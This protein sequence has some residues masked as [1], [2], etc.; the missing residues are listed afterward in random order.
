MNKPIAKLDLLRA[1]WD[2]GDRISALRIAAK[3]FDRSAETAAF[4]RGWDAH[5]NAA[6]YRQIG[7]NPE[8]MT[9]EAMSVLAGRFGLV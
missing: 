5:Q 9:S 2:A 7:K 4:K 1:A 3:F 6:F 8:A